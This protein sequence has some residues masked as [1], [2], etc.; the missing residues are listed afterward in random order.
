MLDY[1]KPDRVERWIEELY[2]E[3]GIWHPQDLSMENMVCTF[4]VC[5]ERWESPS[6][7]LWSNEKR[8]ILLEQHLKGFALKKAFFHELGHILQHEGDQMTMPDTYKAFMELDTLRFMKVAM[9]PFF[10]LKELEPH[11]WEYPRYLAHIF[12]V[13]YEYAAARLTYIR[14]RIEAHYLAEQEQTYRKKQFV[15]C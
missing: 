1:Y 3:N 4:S 2:I 14:R 5:V 8:L 11:E 12:N 6:K 9:M 10:M 15:F 7:S 13:S